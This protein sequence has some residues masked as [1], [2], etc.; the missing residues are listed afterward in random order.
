M[1]MVDNNYRIDEFDKKLLKL[2][3]DNSRAKNTELAKQL[4]VTEGAIRKRIKKLVES[5]YI[6]KFTIKLNEEKLST[7]SAIV[8]ITIAGDSSPG[9]IKDRILEDVESCD[10]IFETTGE[11]DFFLIF[12][13]NGEYALKM[14]IEKLRSIHGVKSTK[15]FVALQKSKGKGS[16]AF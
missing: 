1:E 6:E 9:Q 4:N 2:L 16:S 14:A 3:Q 7:T 5:R 13:T 15:T 12:N 10:V 8:Q 11:V